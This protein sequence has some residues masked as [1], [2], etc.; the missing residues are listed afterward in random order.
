[1][2]ICRR[3][4]FSE[5]WAVRLKYLEDKVRIISEGRLSGG[6]NQR[7]VLEPGLIVESLKSY[8]VGLAWNA[9]FK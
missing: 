7:T 8:I 5:V 2:G 3:G 9:I 4:S 6:T 1:M